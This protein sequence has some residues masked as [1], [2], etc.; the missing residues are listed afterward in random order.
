[1]KTETPDLT[2]LQDRIGH[3][4]ADLPLL[5]SALTHPSL[6]GSVAE[7][8]RGRVYERLEFLGDRVLGLCIAEWLYAA[9]PSEREGALAKRHAALVN[10][11]MLARL[12]ETIDL[13]R[14]LQ[15][16]R[17]SR[18]AANP[19][20]L[21]DAMEALIGAIYLDA[22]LDVACTFI[23]RVWDGVIHENLAP[24]QDDKTALQ[25]WAQG[26]GM[27]LPVYRVLGQS[28]PSHAPVFEVEVVI[29]AKGRRPMRQAVGQ[30][31]SKRLAEKAA[32]AALLAERHDEKDKQK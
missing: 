11:D 31:S 18:G 12:A 5:Q 1:M 6:S 21:G 32:A 27:A 16:A 23:R 13:N 9:Y 22:G 29:E 14:Y 4:F 25:E 7:V 15:Q 17:D 28:G 3:R 2:P 8:E 20:M 19:T 26:Q 30:G 10:R 24:P